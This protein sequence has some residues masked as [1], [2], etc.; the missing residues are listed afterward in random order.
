MEAW[1]TILVLLLLVAPAARAGDRATARA[2]FQEGTKLYNLGQYRIAREKFRQAYDTR[3]DAA[4]L[5]NIG[6]CSRM[7]G[8]HEEAAPSYRAFLREKPDAKNR[9]EVEDFIMEAE[10]AIQ[11][12]AQAEAPAG[13]MAPREAPPP[14][15][16]VA[17]PP[18]PPA[19]TYKKWWL[20]TAVAAGAVVVGGAVT[21]G[22]L[23]SR[24]NDAP[25]P[26][27]S[28]GTV[29]VRFP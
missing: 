16:I 18:L 14:P 11:R 27:S 25:D 23:A 5:F 2:L 13:T 24:P 15:V 29:G 22:V 19:P 6:Q 8:E 21:A 7:L 9:T 3:P 28:L 17:P 10:E 1:R 26:V 20:W 4:F 12:K